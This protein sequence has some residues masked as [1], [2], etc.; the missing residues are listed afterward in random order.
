MTKQTDK[1]LGRNPFI[2]KGD[3][4]KEKRGELVPG[5]SV[6]KIRTQYPIIEDVCKKLI[7]YISDQPETID[8]K[9]LCARY[10]S[11]VVAS[12]IYGVDAG[13]FSEE[14]PLILDRAR[15]IMSNRL[16]THLKLITLFPFLNKFYKG[17]Y[18]DKI[19][20][21][22]F[23][24]LMKD[25]CIHRESSQDKRADFLEY[26][27][28]LQQRKGSTRLDTAA[29][30]LTF[31]LDGFDT[32]SIFMFFVLYEVSSGNFFFDKNFL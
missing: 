12:C 8:V 25:A 3:E 31:L 30:G 32:S 6:V 22:F 19:S 4:W 10:T 5:F 21:E 17:C 18:V 11:N 24:K 15:N 9:D 7:K 23:L 14:D 2:L 26:L 27:I 20:E 1:L 28:D 29:N 13:S 16:W